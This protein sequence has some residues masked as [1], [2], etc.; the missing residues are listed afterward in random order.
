MTPKQ[1]F[2]FLVVLGALVVLG[3]G[4][5]IYYV[6][7]V[8]LREK[9]GEVQTLETAIRELRKKKDDIPGLQKQLE[10]LQAKEKEF[11]EI[12]PK[13][14]E[15]EF[16]RFY[17]MVQDYSRKA[18]VQLE[19]ILPVAT[20]ASK[21]GPG[22]ARPAEAALPVKKAAFKVNASGGFY[23]LIAF[24][25]LLETHKRFIKVNTFIVKPKRGA[26]AKGAQEKHECSIE[27]DI[28]TY[29]FSGT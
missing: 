25:Y 3:M 2:I 21:T 18:K 5:G 22:G 11:K 16:T 13:I 12:L 9:E 8:Q 26:A 15:V 24:M 10:D 7:F 29:T 17:E 19:K 27:M 28:S 1:K 23:Q 14:E 6:N 4:A 20:T